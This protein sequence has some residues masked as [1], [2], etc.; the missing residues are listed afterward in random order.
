MAK[1]NLYPALPKAV[2][3][4]LK[5]FATEARL[6]EL[7]RIVENALL[8][9]WVTVDPEVGDDS[10]EIDERDDAALEE[11]L[12]SWREGTEEYATWSREKV[13]EALGLK[14]MKT[15]PLFNE[16]CDRTSAKRSPWDADDWRT[17]ER[18][19]AE[20]ELVPHWHQLVGILKM[21]TVLGEG[22]PVLVMDQVGI[23]KTMQAV[24]LLAMRWVLI[25]AQAENR[26]LGGELGK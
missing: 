19:G 17:V 26:T 9:V 2:K 21:L 12:R 18:E 15:L 23:G 6:R 7:D 14:D 5:D 1:N 11:Q 8:P 22:K 25:K 3:E 16:T 24:G 4:A 13:M 20:I 10:R